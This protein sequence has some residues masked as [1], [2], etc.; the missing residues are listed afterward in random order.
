MPVAPT[1][2]ALKPTAVA[3]MS[4][5][6]HRAFQ[7]GLSCASPDG[8]HQL[9]L[10]PE[11]YASREAAAEDAHRRFPDVAVIGPATD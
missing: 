4:V 6:D 10:L 7:L 3:I 8:S 5:D 11:R 9:R 1:L 2:S